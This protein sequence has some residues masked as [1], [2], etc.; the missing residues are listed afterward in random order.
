MARPYRNT[1]QRLEA[2][3][4]EKKQCRFCAA[5]VK[6]IDYKDTALL[7]TCVSMQAKIYPPRRTGTCAKHQR[8]V[9]ES[10][11]R[12]RFMGLMPYTINKDSSFVQ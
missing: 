12:A 9:A 2:F 4:Q 7:R 3:Q 6:W 10:V 11:K 1:P 5:N 8:M